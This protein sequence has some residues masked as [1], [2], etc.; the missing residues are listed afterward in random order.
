M[1]FWN[2]FFGVFAGVIAGVFITLLID[3]VKKYY[4][5]K[6]LISNLKFEIDFNLKKIDT[7][8]GELKKYREHINGESPYEYF[9]V[10]HLKGLLK[11]TL[12][13]MF[14]DRSL[15]K[16]FDN[17]NI[18]RLQLFY[19]D[20]QPDLEISVNEEIKRFREIPDKSKM[21]KATNRYIK[22]LEVGLTVAKENLQAVKM[23][24]KNISFK[25]KES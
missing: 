25:K 16:Y 4:A 13:Q 17:K 5:Q 7:F 20:F 10:F 2:V 15:Y 19:E 1:T 9:G 18:G 22:Y 6:R 12:K 3:A 24:R 8:F 14:S 21:V 23:I 11:T